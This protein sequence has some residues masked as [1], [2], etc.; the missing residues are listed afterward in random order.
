MVAA[1]LN[2]KPQCKGKRVNGIGDG[3]ENEVCVRRLSQSCVLRNANN[4]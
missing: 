2:A 3:I 1:K 4:N